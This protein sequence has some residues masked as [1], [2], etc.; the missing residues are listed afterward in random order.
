MDRLRYSD[1]IRL[2]EQGSL[3]P[4]EYEK[5]PDKLKEAVISMYERAARK[6]VVGT[7]ATTAAT[8]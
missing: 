1:R 8:T 6:E 4:L 3:G 2:A 5:V 7:V